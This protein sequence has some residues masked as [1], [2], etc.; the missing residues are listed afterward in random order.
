[1]NG[2]PATPVLNALAARGISASFAFSHNGYTIQSRFHLFS[3]SLAGMRGPTTLVD[4]FKANGYEVAYFSAQDETFG[5]SEY[6]VG[7][8]R[9]D[10]AFDARAARQQRFSTYATPGSLALPATVLTDRIVSFLESRRSDRPLFL[11]VNFQ[12]THFPYYHQGLQPLINQTVLAQPLIA[13][14]R[15]EALRAMYL[16]TVA[17]VDRAIGIVLDRARVT[18]GWEP[19]VVVTSDHGESLFDNGFLGHGYALDAVQ[20]RVPLIV[21][22]LPM[23]VTEPFGQSDL[24]NA[25]REALQ[26]LPDGRRPR[27]RLDPRG[28]VFQYLGTFNHPSQIGWTTTVGQVAYDF[29]HNRVRLDAEGWHRPSTLNQTQTDQY[30]QLVRT[31]EAMRWARSRT[32]TN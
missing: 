11:Y 10:V 12:D 28:G 8:D 29:R 7:F 15:A 27:L 24:R 26:D 1:V 22:G 31:W 4:D 23:T 25:I 20:T 18:L 21:A 14:S 19:A 16:N 32:G 17:N 6:A 9:A 3:G 2:Q 5:G 13:S 30:I